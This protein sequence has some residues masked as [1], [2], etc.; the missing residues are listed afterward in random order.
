MYYIKAGEDSSIVFSINNA[1]YEG[2][3]D[4]LLEYLRQQRCGYN[5][6]WDEVCHQLDARSMYAPLP[7]STFI[8]LSGGWHDAGDD[9]KY[10]LTSSYTTAVML[11]AYR[12]NPRVFT[13]R[14][15]RWGQPYSNGIPDVLD[16]ARWGLDWL[17]KLHPYP[18]YLYHQVGDDRDHTGWKYPFRDSS[19]YGWGRGSYRVGYFANGKPQGLGKYKSK[20]DGVANLAGRYAAAMAMASQIWKEV[21]HDTA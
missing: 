1:I 15:N 4:L 17:H 3:I 20:S 13:D 2:V 18:D 9:L 16:E 21:L 14:V 19:D 5:P 8:D 11:L 10:L 12:L 7:D 6:F